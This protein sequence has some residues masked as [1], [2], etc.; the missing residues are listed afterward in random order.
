MS[1]GL[2]RFKSAQ[3]A[4]RS[5]FAEALR[6]I[7]SGGK[8][9][10][11]IWYVFPQLSGLGLSDASRFFAI[12]DEAE[13][14][15]YLRDSELRGRLLTIATAVAEQL[16]TGLS[17]RRLMGSDV[18]ARKVVSSLTLF[19][20]V[21]RRLRTAEAVE[22]HE[23]LARVADAVLAAAAVEGYPPCADTLG[24]LEST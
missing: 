13:A 18:D 14:A 7:Q 8:T 21:A 15:A 24:R 2:E 22:E 19:G 11:W 10:H 17:L 12:A 1:Q 6:E 4:P 9:G 5:G 3:E 16:Q 23:A 20:H